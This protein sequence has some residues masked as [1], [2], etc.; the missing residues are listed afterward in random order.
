MRYGRDLM[1]G[2][3]LHPIIVSI[4]SHTRACIMFRDE[5]T[6]LNDLTLPVFAAEDNLDD[7]EMISVQHSSIDSMISGCQVEFKVQV[8]ARVDYFWVRGRVSS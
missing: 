2:W 1:K 6:Q 7:C 3:G 8:V 4:D 5:D